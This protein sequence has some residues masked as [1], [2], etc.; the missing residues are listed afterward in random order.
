MGCRGVYF[1]VTAEQANDLVSAQSDDEALVEVVEEI[2][3]AWDKEHLY[4][5]DKAWDAI[6][7]LVGDGKVDLCA[8]GG[9]I[10]NTEESYFV[11]LM[12]LE[13]VRKAITIVGG[14][15]ESALHEKYLALDFPGYPGKS[16]ED[17]RY[18]WETLRGSARSSSARPWRNAR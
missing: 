2:E 9:E 6:Y 12:D 17:W 15:T 8:L 5:T 14:V 16:E 10:L 11:V 7:R 13:D 18:T 1:A 4:E 3:E